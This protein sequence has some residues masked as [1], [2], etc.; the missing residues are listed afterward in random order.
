MRTFK[1][2]AWS[3]STQEMV[4]CG[5][6]QNGQ[7]VESGYQWFDQPKKDLIGMESTGLFDKDG[8]EIFEGDL[9][10][11]KI[12]QH[13]FVY[14]IGTVDYRGNIIQCLLR[15]DNT[16]VDPETEMYTFE[17]RTIERGMVRSDIFSSHELS[18]VGNVHQNPDYHPSVEYKKRS[19]A[20]LLARG[21]RGGVP[22]RPNMSKEQILEF[23]NGKFEPETINGN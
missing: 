14:E 19:D 20:I 6:S 4:S 5:I 16:I 10:I 1:F 18:V 12:N 23:L 13:F 15:F 7:P 2:R 3:P 17:I 22:I 21:K 9:V 11:R 8:V